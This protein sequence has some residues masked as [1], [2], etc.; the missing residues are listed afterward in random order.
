MFSAGQVDTSLTAA[1]TS[2]MNFQNTSG[3][4]G[5]ALSAFNSV[6]GMVGQCVNGAIMSNAQERQYESQGRIADTQMNIQL[7]YLNTQGQ[8][9][10][11]TVQQTQVR[12]DWKEKRADAEGK[13]QLVQAETTQKEMTRDATRVETKKLDQMF[14]RNERSRGQPV[15]PLPSDNT[16][17]E[18]GLYR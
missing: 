9:M 12:N 10:E 3:I 5:S 2:S 11:V 13:L 15:C 4:A 1:M 16:F 18:S 6:M 8:K 7:D 17:S 14:S